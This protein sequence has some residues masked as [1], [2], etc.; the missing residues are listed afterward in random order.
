MSISARELVR[1]FG[2]T[3]AVDHVSFEVE[4]GEFLVLVGPSG[5]GKTTTL[6]LLAGLEKADGGELHFAGR[7][8]TDVRPRDR[9]IAMVFQDYAIFPHLTVFENIAYGLRS[10]GADRNTVRTRVPRAAK[11]FRIDHLLARKPRQLSGGERQRVALARAMVRDATV[12]LYDEPLSNL[13]AQLRH[14][15][16]DDI[17]T[18]HREQGRPSVYVTHDQQEAMTMGD[19]VAVMR[20]GRIEQIGTPDDLYHHPANSFVAHFIGTPSINFFDARVRTADDGRTVLKHDA[21]AL[22]VDD[23][24]AAALAPHADRLVRVGVRPEHLHV[25][26]RAPFPVSDD[27]TVKGVVTVVEPTA[28]GSSVYLTTSTGD[29]VDFVASFGV[30]LPGSYLDKEIPLAVDTRRLHLFDVDSGRTLI[31]R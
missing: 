11:M 27:N 18:L 3:R 31:A 26:K 4:E 21:F 5:C 7:E 28:T 8:V 16:R 30:R 17:T 22:V 23:R 14:Q 15:A 12:Y 10:R 19:R 6:R 25:P 9:D 20:S 24:Q 2:E 13:D 29:P 1:T